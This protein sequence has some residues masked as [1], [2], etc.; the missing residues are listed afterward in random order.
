MNEYSLIEQEL[1][2]ARL[3]ARTATYT[4]VPHRIFIEEIAEELDKANFKI[5]DRYYNRAMNNQ[6]VS[7]N[8][9]IAYDADPELQLSFNWSNSYN[10]ILKASITG[11]A[12][13]KIC[14]NGMFGSSTRYIHKHNGNVLQELYQ[15]IR[16]AIDSAEQQME[17][18]IFVKQ[19]LKEIEV[20]KRITSELLGRMYLE[21]E[22]ITSTQLNIVKRELDDPSYDYNFI[23][24]AF[25]LYSHL[26]HSFKEATPQHYMKHHV[27]THEFFKNHF[28]VVVPGRSFG[29]MEIVD[30]ILEYELIS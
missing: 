11:G 2:A 25:E 27:T 28:E 24:S 6:V 4:P 13:Q 17:E 3:P 26:T 8:Y 16:Y 30:D 7:G 9:I 12:Y 20:T 10:K 21:N 18:L 1:L 29:R 14:A 5:I 15:A 23:G 19:R 22:I